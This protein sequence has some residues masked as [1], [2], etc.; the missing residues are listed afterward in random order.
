MGVSGVM[1]CRDNEIL[2]RKFNWRNGFV[3]LKFIRRRHNTAQW[4]LMLT[5]NSG[6]LSY[7]AGVLGC[8]NLEPNSRK[9]SCYKVMR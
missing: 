4:L 2:S 5:D 1:Y 6:K 8:D 9:H 7:H 3:C